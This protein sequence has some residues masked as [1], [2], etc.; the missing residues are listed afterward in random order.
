MEQVKTKIEV[1]QQKQLEDLVRLKIEL[2]AVTK[3]FNEIKAHLVPVVAKIGKTEILGKTLTTY[4]PT[5]YIYSKRVKQKEDALTKL[6]EIE[7]IKEIARKQ[8]GDLTMRIG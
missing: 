4:Y 2:D 3:K 6:K 5:T 7:K 1:N 8:H